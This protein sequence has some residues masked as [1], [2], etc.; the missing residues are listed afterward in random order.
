LVDLKGAFALNIGHGTRKD[1]RNLGLACVNQAAQKE[2]KA[3]F[4]ELKLGVFFW[5]SSCQRKIRNCLKS[6]T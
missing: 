4:H 6:F 1:A 5:F 2:R 3:I